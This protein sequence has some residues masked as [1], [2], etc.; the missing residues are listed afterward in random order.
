MCVCLTRF[1]AF[2][3]FSPVD[4]HCSSNQKKRDCVRPRFMPTH[5]SFHFVGLLLLKGQMRGLGYTIAKSIPTP[6][7]QNL[8]TLMKSESRWR[9]GPPTKTVIMWP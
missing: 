8:R 4:L 3:S 9:R 5:E 1:S 6:T 7:T 2:S